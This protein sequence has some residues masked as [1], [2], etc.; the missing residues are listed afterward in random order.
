MKN[1]I[2]II[3]ALIVF[4]S[5]KNLKAQDIVLQNYNRIVK[6][7]DSL[8]SIK[9]FE[10]S[11]E[12]Y[13][14]AFFSIF[15]RGYVKDRYNAACSWTLAKKYDKAFLHLERIVTKGDF[16]DIDKISNDKILLVLHIDIRWQKLMDLIKENILKQ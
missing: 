5:V 6:V 8:Y 4:S 14:K 16:I 2:I 15:D 9:K 3:L 12:M 11:G 7:A 10:E 13:E 1:K